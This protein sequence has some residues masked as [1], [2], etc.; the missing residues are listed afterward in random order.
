MAFSFVLPYRCFL[1][2]PA[3]QKEK[4]Q[5]LFCQD[6]AFSSALPNWQQQP[7]K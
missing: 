7:A 1:Q 2:L 4:S 6:S 3:A 5:Q